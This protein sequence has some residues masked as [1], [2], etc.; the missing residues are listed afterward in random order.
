MS[1][2]K[3][4]EGMPMFEHFSEDEKKEFAQT[5]YSIL[6]FKNGNDVITEGELS[7][8]LYLLVK[9]TCL[10]TRTADNA[11][12]R[13]SKLSPGEIFGEMSFFSDKPRQSTVTATDD[14]LV[15]KM[16]DNFFEKI[17]P[18]IRAKIKEYL[19][20]LLISRLDNM[21]AALMKI[22]KLMRS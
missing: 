3:M 12:I 21:N 9:G 5:Q 19:I 11:K 17:N 13:L 22:S 1:L 10:I 8:S 18:N 15:L 16:D 6:K 20:E 14:V 4:I 7:K 2:L